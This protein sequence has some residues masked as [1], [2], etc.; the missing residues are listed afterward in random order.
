MD[1]QPLSTY[2]LD[3]LISFLL[4]AVACAIVFRW[5]DRRQCMEEIAKKETEKT[6]HKYGG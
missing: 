3:V 2:S 5:R 4:I 1:G 6:L